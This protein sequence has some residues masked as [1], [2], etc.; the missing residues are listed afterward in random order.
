L[1]SKTRRFPRANDDKPVWSCA[2]RTN[3]PPGLSMTSRSSLHLSE[4]DKVL[5]RA[6]A[7]FIFVGNG[8]LLA[9][10]IERGERRAGLRLKPASR[11]NKRNGS[12]PLPGAWS[13]PGGPLVAEQRLLRRHKFRFQKKLAEGGMGGIGTVR[14][15]CQIPRRL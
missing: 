7:R 8:G 10:Q 9:G 5:L 3:T 13:D 6:V 11:R 4:D 2:S 12:S 14:S 15:Q 1:A